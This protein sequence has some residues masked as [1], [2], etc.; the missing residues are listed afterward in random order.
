MENYGLIV[1]ELGTMDYKDNPW[2]HRECVAQ[3]FYISDPEK[4][5][6][7]VVI[8]GKQRILRVDGV[9]DVEEYN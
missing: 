3:V 2:V 4:Q 1:V 8:S 7:H 5:K 9:T 6:K